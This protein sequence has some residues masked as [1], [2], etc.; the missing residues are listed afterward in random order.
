MLSKC[1]RRVVGI[2]EARPPSRRAAAGVGAR[3][4][5]AGRERRVRRGARPERSTSRRPCTSRCRRAQTDNRD[6]EG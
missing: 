4:A 1:V 6:G 5:G 3:A 2:V